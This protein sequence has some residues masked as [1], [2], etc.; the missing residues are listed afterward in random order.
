MVCI[1][2]VGKHLVDTKL[3]LGEQGSATRA[4]WLSG[5]EN[6]GAL[7]IGIFASIRV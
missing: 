3:G 1:R 7:S 6:G 2:D 4:S 5:I